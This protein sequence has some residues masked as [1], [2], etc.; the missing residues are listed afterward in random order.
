MF[1]MNQFAHISLRLSHL[2]SHAFLI[3]HGASSIYQFSACCF[4]ISSLV[5]RISLF[6][7]YVCGF[8]YRYL[9]VYLKKMY[10]YVCL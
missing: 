10:V 1:L 9:H 6:C 4:F 2:F 8:E 5:S 7:F 3:S